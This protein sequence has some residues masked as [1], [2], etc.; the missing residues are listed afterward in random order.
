MQASEVSAE[1]FDVSDDD[2]VLDAEDVD[3]QVIDDIP[4]R[5]QD[6]LIHDSSTVSGSDNN[7]KDPISGNSRVIESC[8]WFDLYYQVSHIYS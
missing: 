1:H 6:R 7:A 8:V 5:T 3:S 2:I 4:D